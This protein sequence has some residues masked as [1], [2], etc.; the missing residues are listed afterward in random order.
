MPNGKTPLRPLPPPL[1]DALAAG[2]AIPTFEAA[3]LLLAYRALSRGAHT[4]RITVI[5]EALALACADDATASAPASVQPLA[6]LAAVAARVSVAPA[7]PLPAS[8][9]R[10]RGLFHGLPVRRRA[11]RAR[12]DDVVVSALRRKFISLAFANPNVAFCVHTGRGCEV[13]RT[14]SAPSIARPEI[15]NLFGM[16]LADDLVSIAWPPS[17]NSVPPN[18]TCNIKIEQSILPLR[19]TGFISRNTVPCAA[20]DAQLISLDALPLD[21]SSL[22]HKLVRSAWRRYS[23]VAAAP[24]GPSLGPSS[25]WRPAFFINFTSQASIADSVWDTNGTNARFH[26]PK[27]MERFIDRLLCLT[28]ANSDI[29]QSDHDSLRRKMTATERNKTGLVV[30][31]RPETAPSHQT[32]PFL[33]APRPFS[34]GTFSPAE[35]DFDQA[36]RLC[37]PPSHVK[38][39]SNKLRGEKDRFVK[40]SVG[41]R[42]PCSKVQRSP[43]LFRPSSALLV[44][45]AFSSVAPEWANPCFPA[46]TRSTRIA[47]AAGLPF[48]GAPSPNRDLVLDMRKIRIVRDDIPRL[49]VIG[50]A[51]KKFILVIDDSG[52]LYAVDQ[53]AASERHQYE[54]LQCAALD[55]CDGIKAVSPG[56]KIFISL[57]AIQA[58]I[59]RAHERHLS[60]WGWILESPSVDGGGLY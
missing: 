51:D 29:S 53:H 2:A 47:S 40:S 59:C 23:T 21:A 31:W 44:S 32:F 58:A 33:V 20:M 34:C 54:L 52:V 45:R 15:A 37:V 55:P 3:A 24:G 50:Q 27:A 11:A 12:P 25:R 30:G 39:S 22:L 36:L 4:V 7:P 14:V 13:L 41:L 38:E 42:K 18:N 49:R 28:L 6:A 16:A 9:V 10:V 43:A 57:T 5:P 46:A 26:D 19:V 35:V 60:R 56:R 8:T 48:A 1:R 17:H